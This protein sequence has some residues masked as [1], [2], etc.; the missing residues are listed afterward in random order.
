MNKSVIIIVIAIWMLCT[1]YLTFGRI[2]NFPYWRYAM[3]G[4]WVASLLLL[5]CIVIFIKKYKSK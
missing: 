2:Y 1:L 3:G 5:V 4:T